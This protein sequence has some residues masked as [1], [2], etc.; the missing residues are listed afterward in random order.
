ME[1][2]TRR[3][4]F[5]P[6]DIRWFSETELVRIRAAQQEIRYLLDRGYRMES[7][8]GFIGNHYQFSL[9]QR[10]ALQR[11]TSSTLQRTGRASRRL[12][13]EALR[14]SPVEIDGFN[15]LITL[16][17]ALSG[18]PVLSCD[19]GV[20]RD[21]AGLRGTYSPIGHTA[22]VLR[23]IFSILSRLYVPKV[24]FI[25]DAPVSNSGRLRKLILEEASSF[26]IA[27]EA[28]LVPN[29]DRVLSGHERIIT[30]DSALLD[31]C[32][33]W[34]NLT[35]LI[36]RKEIRDPW[37]IELDGVGEAN[38]LTDQVTSKRTPPHTASCCDGISQR[39]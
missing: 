35:E 23:L 34:F 2:K 20:F 14:K 5:D 38:T 9:R 13:P 17:T 37:I 21:L 1:G 28:Q 31:S 26:E 19:D 24:T 6:E 18:S 10:N 12:T 7:I 16:E 15:L 22:V 8:I 29:A 39:T 3:R 11:S 4:G 27:V 25:L 32:V 33:S 36:M 30:G